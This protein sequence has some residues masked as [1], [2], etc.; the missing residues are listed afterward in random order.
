[1]RQQASA[2]NLTLTQGSLFEPSFDDRKLRKA[3]SIY[4]NLIHG[5]RGTGST[6][7]DYGFLR[8][9]FPCATS[10]SNAEDAERNLRFIENHDLYDVLK[11]VTELENQHTRAAQKR[12]ISV[13]TPKLKRLPGENK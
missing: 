8:M 2:V 6:F 12:Q 11:S 1:M 7:S 13:A 10:A 9:A 5:C 3:E 4:G